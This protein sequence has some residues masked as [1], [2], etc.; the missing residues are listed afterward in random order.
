MQY[1]IELVQRDSN[2]NIALI[3]IDSN[4]QRTHRVLSWWINCNN[5]SICFPDK[6]KSTSDFY[7]GDLRPQHTFG[8]QYANFYQNELAFVRRSRLKR[9][10]PGSMVF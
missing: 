9:H 1:W 4:R 6:F 2:T 10:F 8:Q 7:K 5:F 3:R